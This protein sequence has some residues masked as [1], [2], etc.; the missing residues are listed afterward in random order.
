[1]QQFI[2][3]TCV[4]SYTYLSWFY[5]HEIIMLALCHH[6]MENCNTFY[7]FQVT[8]TEEQWC[9]KQPYTQFL[10]IWLILNPFAHTC[11]HEL[12]SK[13]PHIFFYQ[14]P[15]HVWF[16]KDL[17]YLPQNKN[18]NT[19]VANSEFPLCLGKVFAI[20]TPQLHIPPHSLP[21]L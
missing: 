8:N 5:A 2:L 3:N 4:L 20:V 13:I 14:V 17:L 21:H 7:K 12:K 18:K 11:F 19:Q 1:M 16:H 9:E 15:L 10:S 6:F